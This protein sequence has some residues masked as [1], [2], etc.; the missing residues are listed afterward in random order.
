MKIL[1]ISFSAITLAAVAL[2]CVGCGPA[3][4]PGNSDQ[5]FKQAVAMGE[6]STCHLPENAK[7][8]L[9]FHAMPTTAPGYEKLVR[10]KIEIVRRENI[11]SFS[12]AARP[13]SSKDLD[14]MFSAEALQEEKRNKK[15]YIWDT[16]ARMYFGDQ[17]QLDRDNVAMTTA[18]EKLINGIRLFRDDREYYYA[19]T[20]MPIAEYAAM[21]AGFYR[22]S[23]ESYST[24]VKTLA[25]RDSRLA[26]LREEPKK[27]WLDPKFHIPC[28]I[29]KSA[30]CTE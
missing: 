7:D 28:V 24:L 17:N 2:A 6:A 10:A 20:N 22:Q 18:K 25:E 4:K 13:Q 9:D 19:L 21:Y 30:G 26:A 11:E 29:K 3:E 1:A 23:C 12:D 14:S 15:Y 5:E 27:T 16:S 8:V